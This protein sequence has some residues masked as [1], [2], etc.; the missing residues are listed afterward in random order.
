MRVPDE[1]RKCAAFVCY[2]DNDG[3]KLGGTAFFISIPLEGVGGGLFVYLVTAKHIIEGVASKSVDKKTHIRINLR[4]KP[5]ALVSID[6]ARWLYHPDDTLVDVAIVP[7]APPKDIIDYLSIPIN[8]LATD[9]VISKEA[10]GV[11]DEVFLTGLFRNHYGR[12]KN[13]PIVRIGNIALMPEE[14]IS[15]SN[16]LMDAYLVESRSI[17]GLSGSPVFV[18][19][20]GLRQAGGSNRI[21]GSAFYLLGLMHGHW[22]LP[23]TDTDSLVEDQISGERVNMGIAIVIPVTKI[24]E[25]INRKELVEG[26][27]KVAV[28]KRRKKAPTPDEEPSGT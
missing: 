21:R 26:R 13:L 28:E 10:I 2:R 22:D 7:W 12:D 11:G 19:V 16:G 6:I 17:G 23:V 5:A 1:V 3:Y 9:D 15:T 24:L 25:V 8:M 20:G 18:H 27:A 14:P 4:D